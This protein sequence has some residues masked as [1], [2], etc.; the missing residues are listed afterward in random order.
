[1]CV[2]TS[3]HRKKL[4]QRGDSRIG[5]LLKPSCLSKVGPYP[6][7]CSSGRH[8]N[9]SLPCAQPGRASAAGLMR[10]PCEEAAIFYPSRL[11]SRCRGYPNYGTALTLL[12]LAALCTEQQEC[13]CSAALLRHSM[14]AW[15]YQR[16]CQRDDVQRGVCLNTRKKTNHNVH[17]GEALN[18]DKNTSA[19]GHVW[20]QACTG[21]SSTSEAAAGLVPC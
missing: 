21:K 19:G 11:K 6:Y 1:M 3:M 13:E 20:G 8:K 14:P 12:L 17:N 15:G 18:Q 10:G 9:V 2:G 4:D 7:P 5:P 16:N